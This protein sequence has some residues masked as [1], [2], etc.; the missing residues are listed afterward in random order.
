MS[1]DQP[2]FTPR[3][4]A[5]KNLQPTRDSLDVFLANSEK[6]CGRELHIDDLMSYRALLRDVEDFLG[7]RL[8]GEKQP[9]LAEQ[10]LFSVL[11]RS[12]FMN[13]SLAGAVEEFKYHLQALHALDFRSPMT[14]IKSLE[15]EM[16]RLDIKR[17]RDLILMV[18]F[19]EMLAGQKNIRARLME[20]YLHL[21]AELFDIAV[22]VRSNLLLVEQR[23]EAA[24]SMLST[25][26]IGREKERQLIDEIRAFFK[27]Q[28]KDG[29]SRGQLTKREL[30]S[31]RSEFNSLATEISALVREDA[32]VMRRL[33]QELALRA[34]KTSRAVDELLREIESK[35]NGTVKENRNLFRQVG[36]VLVSLVAHCNREPGEVRKPADPAQDH[37]IGAIRSRMITHLLD[38]LGK[39][40]RSRADRRSG[41]DRRTA[42]SRAYRGPERRSGK[43]RRADSRRRPEPAAAAKAAPRSLVH[44]S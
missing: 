2:I 15:L 36:D 29:L 43:A 41:G 22:Y 34:K 8:A 39:G 4:S 35:K 31:A 32:V 14:L 44:A 42:A 20:R 6:E 30:E 33:F 7:Q 10:I 27:K 1:L 5:F 28:L 9:S 13:E 3:H 37:L 21:A 26:E 38:A 19:Q 24:L 25:F 11:S 12:G 17:Q 18:K 16:G 23:C 40:R